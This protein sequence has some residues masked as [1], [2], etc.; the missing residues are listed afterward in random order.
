[1][2]CP[3]SPLVGESK[4]GDYPAAWHPHPGPLPSTAY[5]TTVWYRG[6]KEAFFPP[7]PW[8]RE[9]EGGGFPAAWHPHPGPLPSREREKS[10]APMPC[11]KSVVYSARA[12][13]EGTFLHANHHRY[14]GR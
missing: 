9:L 13:R 12:A 6:R 11:A 1:M 8:G 10:C 4:R 14:G 2:F 7:S 3:F 5:Y